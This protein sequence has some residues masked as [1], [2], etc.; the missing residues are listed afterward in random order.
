[1]RRNHDALPA[2]MIAVAALLATLA[3]CTTMVRQ[4]PE[5]EARRGEI[6]RVG[7]MPT[8]VTVVRDV[9]KGQ[10]E[11]LRELECSIAEDM[12]RA[13][14]AELGSHG[15]EARRIVA[16]ERLLVEFPDLRF[17]LTQL[18]ES[19][20]EELAEAYAGPEI[21]KAAAMSYE[22]SIGP[23][24]NPVADVVGA[25]ALMFT[26]VEGYKRS[27][28]HVAKDVVI[29][30]LTGYAVADEQLVLQGC[31]VDGVTGDVLWCNAVAAR[32]AEASCQAMAMQL[33]EPMGV[34]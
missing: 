5:F 24:V 12:S 18:Q 7:V 32:D 16:D 11:R 3:G 9:L 20:D 22:A 34:P 13:V 23:Q 27:G 8:E 28:G 1:M 6:R 21:G 26:R 31:L 33:F 4:H 17:E 2:P 30:G 29:A 25:D 15:L 19:Y 10:D 14:A